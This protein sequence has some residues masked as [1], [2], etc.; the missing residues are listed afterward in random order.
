MVGTLIL[1]GNRCVLARSLMEP[2]VWKGMRIPMVT[3]RLMRPIDGIRAASEHCDI[4]EVV[5][6]IRELERVSGVA[7]ASLYLADGQHA[8]IYVLYVARCRLLVLSRTPISL[9]R[10]ICTIGT[11]GHAP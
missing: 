6:N 3:L 9:M 5:E 7:L 11:L 10:M 1:R 2:P 4:E 8:L